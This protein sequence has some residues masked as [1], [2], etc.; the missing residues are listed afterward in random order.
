MRQKDQR[1][2]TMNINIRFVLVFAGLVA[3]GQAR[4]NKV[5]KLDLQDMQ[6]FADAPVIDVYSTSG[7]QWDKVDTNK[8]T[9]FELGFDAE[10]KF[11]GG[12]DYSAYQGNFYVE[13]FSNVGNEYPESEGKTIATA[14]SIRSNLR[15]HGG[16]FVNFDPVEACNSELE[17]RLATQVGKS[18]YELLKEGFVVNAPAAVRARYELTCWGVTK[19]TNFS[20]MDK[21]TDFGAVNVH[22]NCLPSAQAGDK[23]PKP[24]PEVKKAKVVS[25]VKSVDFKLN[26]TDYQGKC[27]API[28]VDATITLNYPV[29]VKYRYV[30]DKGHK[31]PVFTLKKKDKGGTWNLAPWT[32]QVKPASPATKIALPGGKHG[33]DYQ[34][35]MQ[36]EMISPVAKTWPPVNFKVSCHTPPPTVPGVLQT[37]PKPEPMTPKLQALPKPEPKMPVIEAE[38]RQTE[39]AGGQ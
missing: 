13:G 17:K 4:A 23:I 33:A 26:T 29:E 19:I 11:K 34:G 10:C 12:S 15:W 6:G 22:V 25:P 35:W 7:E 14:S 1:R 18:K 21:A 38:P 16:Q 5:E 31:S 37:A 9:D 2:K 39:K 28:K 24:K 20:G 3:A 32:R 30:G 36:L 8:V 27:P